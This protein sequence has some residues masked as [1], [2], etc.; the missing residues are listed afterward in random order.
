MVRN[1]HRT[2]SR[3]CVITPPL[4]DIHQ[5]PD[6]RTERRA[7]VGVAVGTASL[8]N[9]VFADD[10]ALVANNSTDLQKLLTIA[11]KYAQKWK[12]AFNTKKCKV[13]V[14]DGNPVTVLDGDQ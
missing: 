6:Q 5:R 8:N 1:R 11:E 2:P 3:L 14:F 7:G 10:I 13:L 4:P 12:F 9:L